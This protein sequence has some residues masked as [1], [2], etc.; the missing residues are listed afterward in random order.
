[1]QTVCAYI[2]N[3]RVVIIDAIENRHPK[4]RVIKTSYDH[5]YPF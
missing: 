5:A 2:N 1:M 3:V 4:L